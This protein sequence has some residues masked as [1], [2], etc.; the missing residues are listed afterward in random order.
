MAMFT[1]DFLTPHEPVTGQQ[2][3]D[4]SVAAGMQQERNQANV[5][6]AAQQVAAQAAQ[7]IAP[8]AANMDGN[9][10]RNMMNTAMKRSFIKN[11]LGATQ[12]YAMAAANGDDA[13]MQA[14]KERADVFRQAASQQGFD[15]AEFGSDKTMAQKMANY[16]VFNLNAYGDVMRNTMDSGT[17]YN[18]RYNELRSQG[19]SAAGADQYAAAEASEYQRNRINSLRDE[20]YS[21]GITN[22]AVNQYGAQ[23]LDMIRDE[24][25]DAMAVGSTFFGLPINEYQY[26]KKLQGLRDAQELAE[27]KGLFDYG[28]WA[29]KA[30]K[31]NSIAQDQARFKQLLDLQGKE[32]LYELAAK[33]GLS[34]GQ[35]RQSGSKNPEHPPLTASQQKYHQKFEN[36]LE[37]LA[38]EIS[39]FKEGTSATA[40]EGEALD[41]LNSIIA[42][43]EKSGEF[44]MDSIDEYRH[45]AQQ[46]G[47][48][49]Q[50]KYGY[51]EY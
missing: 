41:E 32:A 9:T 8:Y 20:F 40:A 5:N 34:S 39:K 15:M 25:P 23:I 4:A 50:R 30:D 24:N 35:T 45:Y 38:R 13:G 46:L 1:R 28:I 29:D 6:N 27:R 16:D 44:D 31:T 33:Y 3:V 2:A 26:D 14:A 49:L 51:P 37:K 47:N 43:I 48:S 42:E 10:Q 21:A 36:A 19:L 11:I 22:N 12:N 7:A 18:K 17:F